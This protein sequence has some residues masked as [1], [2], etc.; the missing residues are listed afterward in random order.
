[1]KIHVLNLFLNNYILLLYMGIQGFFNQI[2]NYNKPNEIITPSKTKNY[3]YIFFDFQSLI[4]N[5]LNL[6]S[7][8]NYLI[9]LLNYLF[10]QIFNANGDNTKIKNIFYK[11]DNTDTDDFKIMKYIIK[12][13]NKFCKKMGF[14]IDE[15]NNVNYLFIKKNEKPKKEEQ[16]IA[17][18]FKNDEKNISFYNNQLQT[19]L[20]YINKNINTNLE[21]A[22]VDSTVNHVLDMIKYIMNIDLTSD[23]NKDRY[24]NIAKKI[25]D[26]NSSSN[27]GI[28][29]YFDG[30]PS[31]AKIFE[32][33]ERRI[34]KQ[35]E[36]LIKTNIKNTI[37][38]EKS[39]ILDTLIKP[40]M[41]KI[42]N[43]TSIVN[44][45]Y[46]NIC[47]NN[48]K[49]NQINEIGEAEHQ[50]MDYLTQN[51]DKL[52]NKNILI[53]SPDADL[54]L[55][56]LIQK[57]LNNLK[58]DIFKEE[59]INENHFEF[60]FNYN[61]NSD[62]INSP[63][64]IKNYYTDLQKLQE[65][66]GLNQYQILD[67]C[68]IFLILGDDFIPTIPTVSAKSI[69]N[70]IKC[71][72]DIL[73]IN[74]N[75]KIVN[76]IENKCIFNQHNFIRFIQKLQ[77]QEDTFYRETSKNYSMHPNALNSINEKSEKFAEFFKLDDLYYNYYYL[78]NALN[79]S[80]YFQESEAKSLKNSITIENLK[81]KI[82]KT[83]YD[84][85]KYYEGCTFIFDLY[86]NNKI[87]NYQWYYDYNMS[88][89]MF[90][91]LENYKEDKN[92]KDK[93]IIPKPESDNYMNIETYK[94]YIDA[95]KEEILK[96]I[97]KELK[98]SG[99]RAD[100]AEFIPS[101]VSQI[102]QYEEIINISPDDNDML[103]VFGYNDDFY[104]YNYKENKY[105]NI[106]R[107]ITTKNDENLDY[108]SIIDNLGNFTEIT[109]FLI[110]NE[111]YKRDLNMDSEY[112]KLLYD[113]F[114]Q[115]ESDFESP[116]QGGS[117]DDDLKRYITYENILKLYDCTNKKF[118]NKCLKFP[119]KL[120]PVKDYLK[121]KDH[122]ITISFPKCL[123]QQNGGYN[124][125]KKYIKYKNKYLKLKK[126]Y[127]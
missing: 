118:F 20:E 79:D 19:I 119:K 55:L 105:S 39:T 102:P 64:K 62:K 40:E 3:D 112:D 98:P 72:K 23:E 13:Y 61:I 123:P 125:Y 53:I 25:K 84:I 66:M 116:Q 68:F 86:F 51:K 56:G 33:L 12:K 80:I 107:Y 9:Y 93:F 70:I 18:L 43:N 90:H 58:I 88:P 91:I 46:E 124:Y 45:I 92:I 94:Q 109:A 67:I 29:A 126:I 103:V 114:M 85:K 121:P 82:N 30:I 35:I 59:I 76:N 65:N 10:L 50:I 26:I 89:M 127:N 36:S 24:T 17:T 42:G 57:N 96:N 22:L 122:P 6:Y 52:Q 7:E 1:M 106:Y 28:F 95:N 63:Y 108:D 4:Y 77:K 87:N 97:I 16:K 60:S 38:G 100:V 21:D 5:Q 81:K 110:N 74:K 44:K 41:I 99:L 71:Y 31:M 27:K 83:D 111:Q 11:L 14:W 49:C 37:F 115:N 113:D 120:L 101:Y 104:L 2:K 117:L 15:K 75:F 78:I 8:I 34:T 69:P 73:V 54:I 48:I 47:K 32:Q